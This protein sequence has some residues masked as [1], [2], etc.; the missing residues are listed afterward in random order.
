MLQNFLNPLIKMDIYKEPK[1]DSGKNSKRGILKL[2]KVDNVFK[3]ITVQDPDT[4][5]HEDLLELVFE[6]G[7]IYN[8][9]TFD[10]IH[11]LANIEF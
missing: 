3:T 7:K 8:Q 10:K 6:D 1:T 9:P 4:D 2:I 5:I 11:E